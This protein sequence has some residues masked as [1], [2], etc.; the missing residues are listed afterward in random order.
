M[1][2]LVDI[3]AEALGCRP[4]AKRA[5]AAYDGLVSRFGNELAVLIDAP[6]DDVASAAG[7][8]IA[9]GVARVRSGD[10]VIEPGYDGEYGAVKVLGKWIVDGG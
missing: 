9:E 3:V 2:G 6:V 5:V 7:D 1:V 4:Q 8:R 10:I